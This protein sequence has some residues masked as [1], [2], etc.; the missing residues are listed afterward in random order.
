[1][2]VCGP[3]PAPPRPFAPGA[4]DAGDANSST[5]QSRSANSISSKSWPPSSST[6]STLLK[7]VQCHP[8]NAHHASR[9]GQDRLRFFRGLTVIWIGE[10]TKP[11][12]SRSRR[13]TKRTYAGSSGPDVNSTNFGGADAR[14]GWRTGSAAPCPREPDAVAATSRPRN[15]F[16][17]PSACASPSPPEPG[18]APGPAGRRASPVLAETLTRSAHCTRTSS[19]SISRSR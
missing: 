19:R 18:P 1:M 16:S 2:Y 13:S 10:P 14:P 3:R 12:S 4:A 15:A 17:A 6:T 7:H 11:N 5:R 8:H 9:S